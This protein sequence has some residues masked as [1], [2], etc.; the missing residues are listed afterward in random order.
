MPINL[1]F[2]VVALQRSQQKCHLEVGGESGRVD[3]STHTHTHA[4]SRTLQLDFVAKFSNQ[5]D[6]LSMLAINVV[7]LFSI[8]STFIYLFIHF[9]LYFAPL[10]GNCLE[11]L[12]RLKIYVCSS[13]LW[14]V[15]R[16]FR[17]GSNQMSYQ[18]S[19]KPR[20]LQ[21]PIVKD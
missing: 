16:V 8:S 21:F 4:H 6:Q 2:F 7:N 3:K 1:H 18:T 17:L 20:R 13:P 12:L 19:R 10:L 5:I 15:L 11:F 14:F 9:L